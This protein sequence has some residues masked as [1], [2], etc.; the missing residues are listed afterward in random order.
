MQHKIISELLDPK[1]IVIAGGSNNLH[2]PGGKLLYNILQGSY[3]GD[4]YV[5]NPNEI[6]VQGV[7]SFGTVE[8]LP[9]ADLAIIVIPAV[10][11]VDTV[12]K[13]TE[14]G[15]RA[16]IVIS[17]GYS[18]ESEEGAK[19][20]NE[21]V[22]IV[23][24][25]NGALIGP[26]CI[27]VITSKYQAVFTTPV[28]SL[29]PE[30]CD[31]VSGSGAT[32]VFIMESGIPKGLK[33]SEIFSVGNSAMIGVED[34]LEYMDI[35]FN[36]ATSSKI[37]LLYIESIKD[38]DK[39]LKHA[40]SLIRKGCRI[41]AIKAG[42]SE[43]GSRAAFS[44]TGAM[45]SS[46]LAVEALFR[47]AGIVRCFGREE[48]TTVASVFMQK[49]LKGHR[50]AIVTHAGGPAIML[51]DALAGGGMEIPRI[52]GKDADELLSHLNPGSSVSNPIDILATGTAEQLGMAIDYCDIKF[53]NIDA[54]MIIFG[55]TGLSDVF[56]VY[57]LLHDK[58]KNCSKPVYPILPSL[59]SAKTETERFLKLGHINFPDEVVLANALKRVNNT[60]DPAA[61][62][63]YLDKVNIPKIREIIDDTETGYVPE[64]LIQELLTTAGI[65]QVVGKVGKNRNSLIKI[66][67]E[68]GY[69]LVMKII[70][71]VHKTEVG[72]VTL[73]I[74]SKTHLL[75]EY[76][77]MKKIQGFEGVL[78]QPMLTGMELFIGAKYE[79][80]FGHV[81]LCGLGGIF[82]EIIQDIASGL[83][84]L[85]LP[86]TL[87]MIR[88]LKSYKII[89]GAR[90]NE[91][92]DENVFA[93]II[94]R[95]SSLL[96]FATE[97]KEM[98]LNPLIGK[99]KDI[100]VVDAR[101]RIEN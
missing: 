62:H 59:S 27:G 88:S 7:R 17:S 20:E 77:R 64:Y 45:T 31:L 23:G 47:K 43:P 6:E 44:H 36:I 10:M 98:D 60:P 80:K 2:K 70:G 75:A 21:L 48:L 54:I 24:K 61:D 14:K 82:V 55:S 12:R 58:I 91:G 41:A 15:T 74:K 32:A 71:P 49:K 94:M 99:G 35:T 40:S 28:P 19:L 67:G 93:E 90:G 30:G 79:P 25:V 8:Q 13:L 97:I 65:L 16:F 89:K 9:H 73:N 52:T 1:S 51:T 39:L 46:D 50:I 86:E 96:R 72:G 87:S 95:L 78:V 18:E 53:D 85:T 57:E 34:I 33:F 3:S 63:I 92:I 81:V 68:T 26:N 100:F 101:I 84:P 4:L 22:K 69:P 66:A 11:S 56:D 29:S 42:S 37:K 76:K 38:P 83:A 5:L